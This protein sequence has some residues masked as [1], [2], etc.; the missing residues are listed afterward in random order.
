MRLVRTWIV[1]VCCAALAAGATGAGPPSAAEHAPNMAEAPA[2]VAAAATAQADSLEASVADGPWRTLEPGLEL[3]ILP[4]AQPVP[5]GDSLVRA[6]RVDPARFELKLLMASATPSGDALTP[7]QWCRRHRLIGAVNAGMYAKDYRTAVSLL[8]DRHHVNNPRV[9]RHMAV[10]A[11]DRRD[12]GVPPVQIIDREHQNL[13]L[14]ATRYGS[15]VQGIRM[16]A[17]DGRNVWDAQP[18]SWSAVAAGIDSSGHVLFVHV[19][20]PYAMHDLISMLIAMPLGLRNLMYLEGGAPAQLY[21]KAGGE[22]IELAGCYELDSP[23]VGQEAGPGPVP[24]VIGISR[25]VP[26][27]PTDALHGDGPVAR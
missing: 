11:F 23:A 26:L 17:L 12:R 27:A 21:V 8:R 1:L 5:A 19:Q 22:E 9:T 18:R 25:L 2:A 13:D 24:N 15:L 16:I 14:L 20:S 6:L 3:A 7:R 10:L 4:A